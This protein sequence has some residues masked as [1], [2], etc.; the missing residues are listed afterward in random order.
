MLSPSRNRR[1]FPDTRDIDEESLRD[2]RSL[3][4]AGNGAFAGRD[5]NAHDAIVQPPA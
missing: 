3:H 2:Q 5:E 1:H 4:M